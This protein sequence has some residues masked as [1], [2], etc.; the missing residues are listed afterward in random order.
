MTRTE[1]T[2][3]VLTLLVQDR[4]PVH[5]SQGYLV[6]PIVHCLDGRRVEPLFHDGVLARGR[7]LRLGGMVPCSVPQP[8]LEKNI[9]RLS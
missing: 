8:Q 1:I 6:G 7:N 9:V 5:R 2:L 4:V 3:E